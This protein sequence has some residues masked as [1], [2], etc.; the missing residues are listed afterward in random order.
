[1][2]ISEKIHKICGTKPT[3][4]YDV[5]V[6]GN[7]Y[8]RQ[9]KEDIIDNFPCEHKIVK[10]N[11]HYPDLEQPEHFVLFMNWTKST[12]QEDFVI[13]RSLDNKWQVMNDTGFPARIYV[14]VS[15][16]QA[17]LKAV[18]DVLHNYDKKTIKAAI[19]KEFGG[20]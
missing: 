6:D 5:L 11:K 7:I 20:E 16:P 17:Y 9:D 10:V 19:R 13:R 14:D 15:L 8:Y 12:I 3:Y 1:M 18:L 2:T 4:S